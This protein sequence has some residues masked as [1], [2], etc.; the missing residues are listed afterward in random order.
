MVGK[1]APET[2]PAWVKS[3]L[4]SGRDSRPGRHAL[5]RLLHAGWRAG[6][7]CALPKRQLRHRK[8]SEYA[9][10]STRGAPPEWLSRISRS[11][12]PHRLIL[13][14]TKCDS[15]TIRSGSAPTPTTG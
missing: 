8:N 14:G 1:L 9:R 13:I 11:S 10:G 2:F 15:A 5:H 7:A 4:T 6:S 3:D 12:I